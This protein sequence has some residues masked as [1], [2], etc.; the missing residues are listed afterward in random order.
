MD[1]EKILRAGKIA[2]DVKAYA[3][4]IVKK[5]IPLLEIAEKIESKIAELGGKPAFPVNLSINEIAAHYT[6][7]PGDS[8]LAHGLLKVDFGVHIDG[9]TA[10]NA[11]SVDLENSE[12]NKMLIEASETALKKALDTAK[13][14]ISTDE[15]GFVISDTIEAFGFS[16]IIN[17]SG[18]GMEQYDLH[19]GITIPNVDDGRG[20]RLKEGLYA[21]EPFATSGS[22]KVRDGKPSGIY[23]LV[24]EKNPRSQLA[25]QTLGFIESEYNTLPFCSRWLIKKMGPSSSLALKELEAAG[26]LHQ[27][28]QLVEISGN[29][30]SQAEQT[31]LIE[32]DKVIVTTL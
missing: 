26:I 20:L 15:I 4:S 8:T 13:L 27:F 6:P 10:D 31:I 2:S 29:K 1:K 22:G 32:K 21:I 11:F 14:N 16:P 30:V 19:A 7:S 23:E 17:L 25:R 9:W 5:G 18:H 28:A 12:E 3:R 24:S